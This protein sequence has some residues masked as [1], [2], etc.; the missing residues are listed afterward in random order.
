MTYRHI[1]DTRIWDDDEIEVT[2]IETDEG[3]AFDYRREDDDEV[4]EAVEVP[5]SVLSDM[6]RQFLR[7]ESWTFPEAFGG[8]SV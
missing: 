4:L 3:I 8:G 1:A 5:F 6:A 2:L 7:G